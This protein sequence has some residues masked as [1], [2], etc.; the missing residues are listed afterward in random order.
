MTTNDQLDRWL[1]ILATIALAAILAIGVLALLRRVIAVVIVLVGAVFFAYL[2][3]PL[4]RRFAKRLPRWLAIV[5]VYGIFLA[6]FALL[7][8]FVGP[9]I[10]WEARSFALDFPK[11]MQTVQDDLLNANIAL[12]SAVPLSAREGA[13]QLFDNAGTALQHGAVTYIGQ[14]LGIL[15]SV[16]SIVTAFVIIPILTFYILMDLE[17]LHAGLMLIVPSRYHKATEAILKDIDTVLGGFIR[18]QI[19]VGAIVAVLITVMLL[20]LH[21]RYAFLIGLFAGITDIIPYLGAIVGAI[22][23][24]LIAGFTHGLPWALLV[25]A[26]FVG[27]YQLEGHIIAP[28]VVGQRVGLTPLMVIVAILTGAEIGGIVGMFFAVP[29]AG[30]IRAI[31]TR[32]LEENQ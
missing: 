1:R 10:A 3:Y 12:L 31:S 30:V 4:V 23:A 11:V 21:V 32:L 24:V 13:L 17:R 22:P 27:I 2:V 6:A 15:L 20:L 9:K 14:A 25:T 26:G 5:C 28:N 7:M 18:G 8:V 19:I 16:A 29:V